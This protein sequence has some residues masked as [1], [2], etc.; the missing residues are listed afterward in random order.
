MKDISEIAYSKFYLFLIIIT[1]LVGGM[2]Y[3]GVASLYQFVFLLIAL[4]IF[5]TFGLELSNLQNNPI[6]RY[7][8]WMFLEAGISIIWAP[9]KGLAG[10]Y[11]YYVLLLLIYAYLFDSLVNKNNMEYI[12]SLMVVLL[13]A[14]NLIGVWESI[15][16]H[17]LLRD[18]LGNAGRARM[19]AYVPGGFFM[20]PNDFATYIIQI[21]PF[22]FIASISGKNKIGII[23]ILNIFLSAYVILRTE[24]RTQ[25][26]VLLVLMIFFVSIAVKKGKAIKL[27]FLLAAGSILIFILYPSF[28]DYLTQGLASV[29]RDEIAKSSTGGSLGTRIAL[30]KNCGM[31]LLK[32]LGFGVGAGCHR[33][34]MKS[35]SAKYFY[36]GNVVV[37]H[38]ILGEIFADYGIIIGIFFINTLVKMIRMLYWISKT[39]SDN[40]IAAKLFIA[41]LC[42]FLVCG[43]ASSSI[44]Q[45]TSIWTTICYIGAFVRI[46]SEANA[47]NGLSVYYS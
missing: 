22:S 46:T 14:L 23:G 40:E 12:T 21:L 34:V 42:T 35:Y 2:I 26:I 24:S 29:S 7:M 9:D 32:T 43:I 38:N 19:L 16:G 18:Y 37:M 45:L 15:T 3:L 4:V 10:K 33:V 17:H 6:V 36:T 47:D 31:I 39:D 11:T 5:I 13:F 1:S 41:T 30:L 28:T 27:I 25:I 44:I 8:W 20:N